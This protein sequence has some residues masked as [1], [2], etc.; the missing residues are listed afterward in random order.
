MIAKQADSAAVLIPQDADDLLALRRAVSAGDVVSSE[1]TRAVKREREYARPDRGERVRVKISLEV[2]KVQL[3]WS[4]DVLRISGSITAS[5]N[6]E[7]SHG[8]SHSILVRPG[9]RLAVH[10]KEWSA[11]HRRLLSG[12][13]AEP[14]FVIAAIDTRECG[15][16]RISG[17][18]LE[19]L[20]TIRSG[21]AGKRYKS[22]F[23][24]GP[25]MSECV[26]AASSGRGALVAVGPG[27]AKN[28]LAKAAAGRFEKI[29]V[30]EGV[31]SGGPDGVHLF[32][33]SDAMREAMAGTK[34]EKVSRILDEAVRRAS[35][36]GRNFAMGLAEA[37][38][39][40]AAGAVGSLVFADAA[41]RSGEQRVIDVINGA[42]EGG[43][44]VHGV[45][46]STDMGL[47]VAGLGGVV[48]L[49]RFDPQG[50]V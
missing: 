43:A 35:S 34:M 3:D 15:I 39:A 36:G 13:P 46:G 5:S 20:P 2:R 28:S 11:S 33:R 49:L 12:R 14:G 4:I 40:C 25:Y 16:G 32:T 29:Y 24:M 6:E 18:R 7:I 17:T 22:K 9:Q 23:D 31:D 41:L 45:D 38:A 8:S 27:R 44:D 21:A 30:L 1:T 50:R 48:A 19:L 26:E 47:R 42:E 10:K 37:E